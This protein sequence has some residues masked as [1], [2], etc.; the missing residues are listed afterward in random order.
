MGK[1]N[2]K[3]IGLVS[4]AVLITA[5]NGGLLAYNLMRKSDI[6]RSTTSA[7]SVKQGQVTSAKQHVVDASKQGEKLAPGDYK[8]TSLRQSRI[9]QTQLGRLIL[10]SNKSL[11]G[12]FLLATDQS[13]NLDDSN[14]VDGWTAQNVSD[15]A[16]WA[17]GACSSKPTLIIQGKYIFIDD[18]K[19]KPTDT[20]NSYLVYN[21]TDGSYNYFGGDNF[22]DTQAKHEQIMLATNEN[23]QLVFYIDQTDASGP[24]STSTSFK[25]ASTSD[26]GYII[27]RVIDPATM[28]YTDYKINY[29]APAATP[30]Y[31]ISVSPSTTDQPLMISLNDDTNS[32][33][34]D[35]TVTNNT[36]SF[37]RHDANALA[38][39]SQ[40]SATGPY[41]T[42]IEK[43][44]DG[45][46]TSLLPA[47]NTTPLYNPETNYATH[48]QISEIGQHANLDFIVATAR[49]GSYNAT[50][51]IYNKTSSTVY[52]MTTKLI[53]KSENFVPLGAL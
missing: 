18:G 19:T 20:Y 4:L 17:P 52:P 33:Y 29:T 50:P 13:F 21:L 14:L 23:D 40:T 16:L 44:L 53:L 48:F 2:F 26:R 45:P 49:T 39:A 38:V 32:Q 1:M 9:D 51:V 42:A 28:K 12:S 35:G 3:K 31:Y 24:L 46:L 11:G 22:S 34:Y 25:H 37:T 5:G 15:D 43:K 7:V 8:A 6:S 47:F 10:A 27:R 41:D 36:V 30:Y